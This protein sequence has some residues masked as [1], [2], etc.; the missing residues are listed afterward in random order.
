[1]Y[2]DS[3]KGHVIHVRKPPTAQQEKAS[4]V[5]NSVHFLLTF[6]LSLLL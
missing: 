4:I 6:Q 5:K 3:K 2:L 1:M